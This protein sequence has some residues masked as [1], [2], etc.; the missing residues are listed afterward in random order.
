MSID[1]VIKICEIKDKDRVYLPKEARQALN[2]Q[3]GQ[4][5]GYFN[6]DGRGIRLVK[7]KFED[8]KKIK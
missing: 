6:D 3:K 7:I 4:H 2:L 8:F 1:K 5:I